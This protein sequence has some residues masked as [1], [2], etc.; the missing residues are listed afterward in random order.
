MQ[1]KHIYALNCFSFDRRKTIS[2][3][4]LHEKIDSKIVI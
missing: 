1:I 4:T 2:I 3:S